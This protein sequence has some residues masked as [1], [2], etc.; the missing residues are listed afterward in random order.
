MNRIFFVFLCKYLKVIFRK[1]LFNFGTVSV[2]LMTFTDFDA[3]NYLDKLTDIEKERYFSFSNASRRQEFVATRLLR[4]DIF[5][6][7]HIHY[8]AVGAPFIVGE[9]FISISHSKNIVGIAICRDFKVGLDVE[10]IRSN[11]NTIKHKFVSA[12]EFGSLDCDSE[13]ILTMIW[14]GKE[15][16][17]KVSGTKGVNFRTELFLNRMDK[18]QWIG[19]IEMNNLNLKTELN[20]FEFENCII[21][22]NTTACE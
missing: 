18:N 13:K 1:S 4:H 3:A 11:M 7:Q 5:G 21:S 10:V 12:E 19:R 14:T 6:H 2:H 8:D 15:S 9:G 20:I 17:Y 16:L 22:I